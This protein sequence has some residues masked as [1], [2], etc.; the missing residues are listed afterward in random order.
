MGSGGRRNTMTLLCKIIVKNKKVYDCMKRSK[1]VKSWRWL[2]GQSLHGWSPYYI[3]DIRP[4][5]PIILYVYS[6]L[7][8]SFS[9]MRKFPEDVEGALPWAQWCK[10][11][12]KEGGVYHE[13]VK[14]GLTHG[15]KQSK[16][17][18]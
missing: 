6:G 15:N 2:T 18:S 1:R 14:G 13:M 8:I 9:D 17:E 16:E 4:E 3:G 5:T 12:D 7:R 11:F 10:A